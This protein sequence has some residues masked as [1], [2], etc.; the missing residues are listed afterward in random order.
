M[1]VISD[2]IDGEDQVVHILASLPDSYMLVTALEA[3]QDVHKWALVTE[4]L[5]YKQ[6]KFKEMESGSAECKTLQK[7]AKVLPLLGKMDV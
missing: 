5:L 6:S 1:S 4:Q 3:S 2:S 7:W